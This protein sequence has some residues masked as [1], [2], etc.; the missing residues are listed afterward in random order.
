MDI[1]TAKNLLE[2]VLRNITV[3]GNVA[4]E[5]FNTLRDVDA[6]VREVK[7]ILR[8]LPGDKNHLI[9]E[10]END[11]DFSVNSRKVRLEALTNYC[12]TAIKFLDTGAIQSKKLLI[13]RHFKVDSSLT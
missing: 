5:R 6:K 8:D 4:L 12:R 7:M 1:L 9:L 13:T 11:V 10:F 3:N 2:D